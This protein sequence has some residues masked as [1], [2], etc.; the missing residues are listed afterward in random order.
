MVTDSRV[1]LAHV[2]FTSELV[3]L[4]AALETAS[5][6]QNGLTRA[7]SELRQLGEEAVEH[8]GSPGDRL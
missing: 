1:A 7:A 8:S 5:A 3:T 2:V 4:A 6:A